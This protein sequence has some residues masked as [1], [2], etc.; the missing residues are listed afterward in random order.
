M[1]TTNSL[2]SELN[3]L[4][5]AVAAHNALIDNACEA[6][7]LAI[8]AANIPVTYGRYDLDFAKDVWRYP[9]VAQA[10]RVLET[11][12]EDTGYFWASS[13]AR[14]LELLLGEGFNP[15]LPLRSEDNYVPLLRGNMPEAHPSVA[16]FLAPELEEVP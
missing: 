2:V 9:A 15:Q 1:N 12:K 11:L 14:D 5:V 3:S 13:R 7:D 8:E 4:R 6:R 10:L 16:Q